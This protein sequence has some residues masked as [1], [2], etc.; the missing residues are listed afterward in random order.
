MGS[1]SLYQDDSVPSLPTRPWLS[2]GRHSFPAEFHDSR[3]PFSSQKKSLVINIIFVLLLNPSQSLV[4]VYP[5]VLNSKFPEELLTGSVS[6]PQL[7]GRHVGEPV[8]G[9]RAEVVSMLP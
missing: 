5:T 2:I 3:F 4:Q 6:A 9:N 7:F 8:P 1:S